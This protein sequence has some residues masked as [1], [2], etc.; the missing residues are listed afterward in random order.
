[1]AILYFYENKC[2]F[3]VLETGLGGM[4]DCTNV[5]NPLVSIITSIGYDHMQILGNTLEEIAEQKAGIIKENSDTICVAQDEIVVNEIIENT[6]KEKN[7]TLHILS[8]KR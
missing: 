6:C 7:N 1:M 4:Y 8:K 5:V 3:V 2:D